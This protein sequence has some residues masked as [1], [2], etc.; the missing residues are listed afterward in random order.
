MV[1]GE[2][3]IFENMESLDRWKWHFQSFYTLY[4]EVWVAFIYIKQNHIVEYQ[5]G[6][7]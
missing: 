3:K 1:G 5:R 7:M 4:T 2:R 6:C